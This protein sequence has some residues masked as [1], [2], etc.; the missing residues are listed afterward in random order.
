MTYSKTLIVLAISTKHLGFCIAGK[1]IETNNWVRPVKG[2]SFKREELCNLL[3]QTDPIKIFDIVEMTFKK[4][5]P[6]D[7]QP[8]NELVDMNVKWKYLGEFQIR[9]LDKLIDIDQNDF[10]N[11]IQSRSINNYKIKTLNLQNSLR[12]IKLTKSNDAR[13]IYQIAFNQKEYKPRL[14]FNYKGIN[15][16]LP[17]TD[18]TI[19][20]SDQKLNPR[21]LENAYITIG[22]GEEFEYSHYILVVMLKEI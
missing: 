17:I 11:L 20:K 19:P 14:D 12:L 21:I 9:H 1:D 16:N 8:E 4:E 10:L 22:I 18:P 5:T 13:M 15:Y 3:H 2:T 6:E 7:H